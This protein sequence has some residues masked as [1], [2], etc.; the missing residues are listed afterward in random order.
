MTI[1]ASLRAVEYLSVQELISEAGVEALAVSVLP[2]RSWFDVRGLSTDR[3]DPLPDSIGDELRPV[4]GADVGWDTS[5]DEQIG[6]GVDH[7]RRV[8][9]P[10][11]ADR[12]AL[13][14]E[15]VDDVQCS[16]GSTVFCSMMDKVV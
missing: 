13:T 16:I 11:H 4:V 8:Q 10:L 6:Q 5:N 14:A 12:Q 9:L 15:L 2:K 3:L 1:C 7:V